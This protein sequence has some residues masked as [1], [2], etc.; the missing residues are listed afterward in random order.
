MRNYFTFGK[1]DSRDFGVY[2][3]GEGTYDAPARVYNAISVPGRNGDLLIDEHKYENVSV[4]YPAFIAGENFRE[5]LAAFRSAMLSVDGY[6][7]LTDTYHPDEFRIGYFSDEIKV[8]AASR[9]DA[10]EFEIVF[11]CK[12]QRFLLYGEEIVTYPPGEESSKNKL[13]YPYYDTTKETAG[14]ILYT[15]C[16]DGTITANG[17]N[18]HE[19]GA[20]FT[21]FTTQNELG[22]EDGETYILNGCPQGGGSG[23]YGL[24][25]YCFEGSSQITK[26]VYE[27]GLSFVYSGSTRY[28]LTTFVYPDVT[29]NNITFKPM[30]RKA[31]DPDGWEPYF[32]G[33]KQI[34]NP[35][36]FA[37]KP[38]IRV[39]FA[40]LSEMLTQ[41][42]Y[43]ASP[44]AHSGI[45]YTVNSD[46][47]ITANGTATSR[48][49]FTMH[50]LQGSL[51]AGTYHLSGCPAGGTVTGYRL[52][53]WLRSSSGA[54]MGTFYE[55]G[56]GIDFTVT[57]AQA[58]YEW[59]AQIYVENGTTVNNLT[60]EPSLVATTAVQTCVLGVG[61]KQIRLKNV[62]PYIDID[63]E[64][65]DC[66][67]G[68]NNANTQVDIT[69]KEF[70]VLPPGVTGIS[71]DSG[72][73]SVEITPRWFRL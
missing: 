33:T 71:F 62:Y 18:N 48:S 49:W 66:Y 17:T 45:E 70:P 29:V 53:V 56:D 11:N 37:S 9:N 72:I 46:G 20:N 25:L 40:D 57:S 59:I 55:Y 34:Y 10:G 36:L 73:S 51:P 52:C 64:I 31:S 68:L 4:R 41:P 24:I 60:F 22:L 8:K 21:I 54:T 12:P 5:N 69:D 65:E 32:D 6:A 67:Y 23:K 27:D 15:D 2:I 44:F 63:T 30:I 61:E 13:P 35:T 26:Y 7:R 19:F 43:T 42:Y 28:F 3:S 50:Y 14:G 16:G 38:L 1:F 47:T 39:H 58:D